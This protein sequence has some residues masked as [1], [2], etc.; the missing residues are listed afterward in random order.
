MPARKR[1][2]EQDHIWLDSP[3]FD[4]EKASGA[5]HSGLDF[6]GDE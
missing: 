6:V 4:R 2:G 5:P 1:L 3:M